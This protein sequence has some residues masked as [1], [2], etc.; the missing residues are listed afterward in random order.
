LASG[1]TILHGGALG[2]LALTV[3]LALRLPG[4]DAGL[5]LISRSHPGELS[6]C[7]P[8]VDRRAAD[9]LGMHWL[10]AEHDDPPPA[11]LAAAVRDARVLNALG[12]R[13]S[14]VHERLAL[15]APAE[16]HS[17]DPRPRPGLQRHIL[18]QWQTDLEAGGLLVPKCIHHRPGQRSLGVPES[19]RQRG[20]RVLADAD[21]GGEVVVVHPGS[22]GRR[23]CWPLAN[24]VRVA[25]RLRESGRGVCLLL[26]PT[27]VEWWSDT[28]LNALADEFPTLRLPEP[29][30][31][32]AALAAARAVVA[33]DSG[34][35][36]L[37]ALLGTP[38]VAI[39]GPTSPAVWQPV[40][41][42][43]HVLRGDAEVRPDNWG[44]DAER[45]VA[46]ACGG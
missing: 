20:R 24:F 26:G 31:L 36:H 5:H 1:W 32:A 46:L 14:S 2:D 35:A 21:A 10:Y 30:V 39:F 40:G 8:A 41:R 19:L 29:D 4:T 43:V 42:A 34:P 33:N 22:G 37:A 38:T 13:G 44:L 11:G 16:L 3:H 27:E 17:F 9:G 12:D 18:Q 45:V 28:D 25:R 15:L 6:A 23:K 7:R